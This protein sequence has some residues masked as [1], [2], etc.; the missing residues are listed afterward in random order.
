[1]PLGSSRATPG[2]PIVFLWIRGKYSIMPEV[3]GRLGATLDTFT[4]PIEHLRDQQD[5]REAR[6][7]LRRSR[8]RNPENVG[9]QDLGVGSHIC[10][11]DLRL[12]STLF[13]LSCH[14]HSRTIHRSMFLLV[15]RLSVCYKTI[16]CALT[17]SRSDSKPPRELKTQTFA[18]QIRILPSLVP[19][20]VAWV[21]VVLSL[22]HAL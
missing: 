22:C 6:G 12:I 18:P 2:H 10:Y 14:W 11:A 19:C 17:N 7:G 9:K 20:W 21:M 4:T 13:T 3:P 5:D 15:G 1:M 8:N 16:I